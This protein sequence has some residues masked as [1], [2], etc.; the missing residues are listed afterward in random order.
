MEG[1]AKYQVRGLPQACNHDGTKALHE[2]QDVLSVSKRQM[3]VRT[4]VP[5]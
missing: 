1:I 3:Y 4:I 2:M 5:K